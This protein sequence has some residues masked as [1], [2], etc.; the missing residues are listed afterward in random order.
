MDDD[1]LKSTDKFEGYPD[2]YNRKQVRVR[3]DN[4]ADDFSPDTTMIDNTD[5]NMIDCWLYILTKYRSEMRD[6]EKYEIY[7][8]NGVHGK[9]HDVIDSEGRFV[10]D[11]EEFM[12][13]I[14]FWCTPEGNNT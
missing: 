12:R 11:E 1:A 9:K 10:V 3:M 6:F 5:T 8:S 2:H 4:I 14:L 7:D 13:E